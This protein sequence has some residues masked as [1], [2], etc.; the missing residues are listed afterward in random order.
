MSELNIYQKMSAITNELGKV[1]KNLE[2]GT[3]KNQYKA[4]GEADILS[5]VK[6][7]EE[8][9]GIYS[10]PFSRKVIDNGIIESEG[11]DWNTKQKVI[12]KQ[13]Y[14]RLETI[15]RFVNVDIPT[16]FID[17]TTYGDGMDSQ[18]KAVG[19]AMT[20][21]DKYALM[22]AYKITTGDDP[23]P[24]ASEDMK[25]PTQKPTP[26][27]PTSTKQTIQSDVPTS[28]EITDEEKT[29]QKLIDK[30]KL[31]TLEAELKRTGVKTPQ[32]LKEYKIFGLNEMNLTQWSELMKRLEKVPV[33]QKT[34]L[35]L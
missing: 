13:I 3:G 34:D 29:E 24:H 15:Y 25:T 20:Y 6:P 22:K 21:G 11:V 4:V 9:F 18:D 32:I 35:G 17:I 5:A 31:A 19:K 16:E 10:Y 28:K 30:V 27:K 12:K 26:N 2:V 23:D 1:A 8:K 14:L 33:K 7:I